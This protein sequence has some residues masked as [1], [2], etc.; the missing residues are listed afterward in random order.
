[1]LGHRSL[2]RV[3]GSELVPEEPTRGIDIST[4]N[5]ARMYNYFLGGKDNFAADRAAAERVLAVAPQTLQLARQNRAFLRRAVRHLITEVGI[6]QFIDIGA[7]LPTEGNVH[8]V[9]RA[10]NPDARVAYVDNDPVV[11]THARALLTRTPGTIAV[12]GDLRRPYELLNDPDLRALIDFD[13]PVAV[14][15]V[16]VLHFLAADDKPARRVA[17]I[18]DAL[19]PGSHLVLSHVTGDDKTEA[20][21]QGAAIYKHASA[22]ITLRSREEILGLFDGFRLVPPGLVSLPAWR[23]DEEDSYEHFVSRRLPTWFWCGVGALDG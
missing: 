16:A 2:V 7:G 11:L 5:A 18:R 12:R 6:T 13:R 9:A 4:P 17:E 20:A 14:L 21:R 1:M 8:E 23:P 10:L 3:V 19:A 22:T 15:T